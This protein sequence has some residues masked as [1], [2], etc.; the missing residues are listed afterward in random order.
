M[1][2]EKQALEAA[3]KKA[4]G[5]SALGRLLGVGQNYV[6][7]WR[8][9]GIAPVERCAAIEL[10]TGIPA[11]ELRPDAP[12]RRIKDKSWPNKAGRPVLDYAE[13]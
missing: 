6:S 8:T 9:R 1:S 13:A 2:T 4:E 5:V 12:W 10:H 11:D 3:I 7:N